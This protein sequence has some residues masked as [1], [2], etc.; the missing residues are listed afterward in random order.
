MTRYRRA[1]IPGAT[2][3]FTVNLADR[4]SA[5]LIEH[6]DDLRAAIRHVRHHHPFRIDAMTVLPDHLHAVWT[7]PPDDADYSL[8]WRLTKSFFSRRIPHGEH[9]RAS[10]V[11]KKERGLWQRRYWEHLIRDDDDLQRHVDYTHFNPVRH[12]HV[13]RVADWPHSTF[14][15]EVREGRLPLDWGVAPDTIAFF[16]ERR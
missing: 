7:L 12:G 8:R 16:G 11:A 3:F 4:Q 5:L 15:R 13:T 6:I 9:R 1:R 14:H 10:R 2:Y